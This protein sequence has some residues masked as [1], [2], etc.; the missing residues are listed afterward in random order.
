MYAG[1]RCATFWG[2][3]LSRKQILEYLSFFGKITRIQTFFGCSFRRIALCCFDFDH[4]SFA[5]LKF[6]IVV[7]ILGYTFSMA[8]K[9]WGIVFAKIHKL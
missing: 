8:C 4:I 7:T 1:T 5:W 3:L 6:C 2:A 9:L